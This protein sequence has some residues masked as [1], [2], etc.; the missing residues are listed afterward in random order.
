MNPITAEEQAAFDHFGL[1]QYQ[2]DAVMRVREA[3]RNGARNVLLCAPTAAGKTRISACVVHLSSNRGKQAHFVVDRENLIDQTSRTFDQFKIA[4]GVVQQKHWRYRPYER[5][6]VLSV[7][8]VMRRG[9]PDQP[10]PDLV[11]VDEAHTVHAETK[12]RLAVG[13]TYGL[14]LTATPFTKGLGQIYDTLINVETTNRLIEQGAL[15]PFR[16]FSDCA[17][18]SR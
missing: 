7:Q 13:D 5:A 4:H 17:R 8:T 14:G 3:Y 12:K 18:L 9:W 6:Q 10:K 15:V 11:V 2:I 16:I 1:R